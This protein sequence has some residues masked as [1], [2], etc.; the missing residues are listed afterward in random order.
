MCRMDNDDPLIPDHDHQSPPEY[1]S[2]NWTGIAMDDAKAHPVTYDDLWTI[3]QTQ[4]VGESRNCCQIDDEDE[5]P[6][7]HYRGGLLEICVMIALTLQSAAFQFVME[8]FCVIFFRAWRALMALWLPL[9]V[10]FLL[11]FHILRQLQLKIGAVQALIAQF[12]ITILS[13]SRRQGCW[14]FAR[15]MRVNIAVTQTMR[16]TCYQAHDT[17]QAEEPVVTEVSIVVSDPEFQ[18][19]G[20]QVVPESVLDLALKETRAT[21]DTTTEKTEKADKAEN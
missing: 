4:I 17:S 12:L 13:L 11:V 14:A 6:V 20:V 5:E 16:A 21:V 18:E 19:T 7:V 15:M 9:G 8:C 2:S 3:W 1:N 10:P